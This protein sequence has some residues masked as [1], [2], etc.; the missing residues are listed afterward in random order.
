MKDDDLDRLERLLGR[1]LRV[2]ALSSTSVLAVGLGLALLVPSLVA[3]Q[4]IIRIGHFVLLLTP[5]ARVVASV[6]EYTNDRDW[7]FAGLTFIVL[8]IILG[9]LLIGISG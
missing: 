3:A 1:V 4:A 2:G 8:A 5:V 6:V 7:L 9:S